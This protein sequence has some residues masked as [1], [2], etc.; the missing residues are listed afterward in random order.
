MRGAGLAGAPKKV[1]PAIYAPKHFLI[2]FQPAAA[3]RTWHV[4]AVL[5]ASYGATIISV[6]LLHHRS[7]SHDPSA[8]TSLNSIVLP[9]ATPE[10]KQAPPAADAKVGAALGKPQSKLHDKGSTGLRKPLKAKN[11]F[12]FVQLGG[13]GKRTMRLGKS[14]ETLIKIDRSYRRLDIGKRF[15]KYGRIPTPEFDAKCPWVKR[16]AATSTP[17]CTVF[18]KNRP[19]GNEGVSMWASQIAH[20]YIHAKQ[21][22]C[23]FLADYDGNVEVD[24]VLIPVDKAN[25]DWRVSPEFTCEESA[26]CFALQLTGAA[27]IRFPGNGNAPHHPTKKGK[28]ANV[29]NYRWAYSGNEMFQMYRSKFA[30]LT[31]K[32]PGFRIEDGMACALN[33]LFEFAPSAS[34][35]EPRLF[36]EILPAIQDVNVLVLSLYVRTGRTDEVAAKE[37]AGDQ[38][39]AATEENIK[40]HHL[41]DITACALRVEEQH[42]KDADAK[43]ERIVWLVISDGPKLKQHV[44]DTYGGQDLSVT[45][46]EAERT[47]SRSVV[48]TGARGIHTRPRRKPSTDEFAEAMVDWMLIGESDAL[49]ANP[50]LSFGFTGALRTSRPFFDANNDCGRRIMVLD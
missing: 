45:S 26:G 27:E 15:A 13:G 25:N 10:V 47:V 8:G 33:S 6:S 19:G 38:K 21:A 42:L 50:Q 4:A 1:A 12:A 17:T 11:H 3:M 2:S 46:L 35:Y 40:H 44:V 30:S 23:Q 34:D 36:S 24:K 20:G 29:P 14:N 37:E 5:G 16:N 41:D 9:P 39:A 7:A 18:V 32:L 49:I 48:V 31:H 43:F 28:M 22:G